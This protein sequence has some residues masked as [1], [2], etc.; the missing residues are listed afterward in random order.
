MQHHYTCEAIC[1]CPVLFAV[2][3]GRNLPPT[4]PLPAACIIMVLPSSHAVVHIVGC[5]ACQQAAHPQGRRVQ[6]PPSS[7]A[8][9]LG[10]PGHVGREP[11]WGIRSGICCPGCS[12][13]RLS[14]WTCCQLRQ[15]LQA[16]GA[17]GHM[18]PT[19]LEKGS[20]QVD[21]T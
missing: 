5:P 15:W 4:P 12:C 10:Q 14:V 17:R 19:R 1:Y 2:D 9:R 6:W 11:P 18:Q 7:H 3:D 8:A 13:R 20:E 16:P 21:R